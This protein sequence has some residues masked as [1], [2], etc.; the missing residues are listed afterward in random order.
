MS[1]FKSPDPHQM[2]L[3]RV[4]VSAIDAERMWDF[5]QANH[6]HVHYVRSIKKECD[7]PDSTYNNIVYIYEFLMTPETYTAFALSVPITSSCIPKNI[8]LE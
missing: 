2:K 1:V 8:I 5:A 6:M 3:F 7:N 4:G